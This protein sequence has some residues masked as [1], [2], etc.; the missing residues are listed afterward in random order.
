MSWLLQ[1]AATRARWQQGYLKPL[2]LRWLGMVGAL[3][4]VFASTW[5]N[6]TA[7]A[8]RAHIEDALRMKPK[9]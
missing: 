2:F 9:A 3:S 8:E 7:K 6:R 1:A 5:L 4:G